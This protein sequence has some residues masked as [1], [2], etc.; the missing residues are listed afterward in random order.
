MRPKTRALLL[1]APVAAL[2]LGLAVS[3]SKNKAQEEKLRRAAACAGTTYE[4]LAATA[5]EAARRDS[6]S[7]WA[8][9]DAVAAY[10]CPRR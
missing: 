7:V 1:G 4:A 2:L 5:E 6:L 10:A 8:A 3:G 9:E